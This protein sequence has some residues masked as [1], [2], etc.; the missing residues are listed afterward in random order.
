MWMVKRFMMSRHV[1]HESMSHDDILD[2]TYR[3]LFIST[4]HGMST[5]YPWV[6]WIWNS[7][8]RLFKLVKNDVPWAVRTVQVSHAF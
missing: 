3:A 1:P 7:K 4:L 5:F 2:S 6:R 8:L